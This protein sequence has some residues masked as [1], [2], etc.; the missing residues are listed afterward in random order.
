[1]LAMLALSKTVR[2]EHTRGIAAT[3]AAK[4]GGLARFEYA[5]AQLGRIVELVEF[6]E[7]FVAVHTIAYVDFEGFEEDFVRFRLDQVFGGHVCD[8]E[9]NGHEFLPVLVQ[10][11]D[12]I[13][14]AHFGAYFLYK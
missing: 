8:V 4:V 12:Q 13:A 6:G 3:V 9:A 1:M 10:T 5:T 11:R 14:C 7:D 2:A